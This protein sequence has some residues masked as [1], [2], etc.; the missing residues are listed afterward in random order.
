VCKWAITPEFGSG[1]Q[2]VLVGAPEFSGGKSARTVS[3]TV[4]TLNI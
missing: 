2:T 4:Q 3:V 1:W